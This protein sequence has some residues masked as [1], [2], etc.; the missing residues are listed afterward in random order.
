MFHS[1]SKAEGLAQKYWWTASIL[2]CSDWGEIGKTANMGGGEVM[3][4][5]KTMEVRSMSSNM[6]L[7]CGVHSYHPHTVRFDQL[8]G[9]GGK[10]WGH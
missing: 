4:R 3:G 9:G 2:F 10:N 8:Y 7:V 6:T 5:A 1:F